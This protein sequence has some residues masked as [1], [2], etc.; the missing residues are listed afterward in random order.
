M[1]SVQNVDPPTWTPIWTSS[2]LL[3]PDPFWTPFWTPCFFFVSFLLLLFSAFF[4]R[5]YAYLVSEV[6]SNVKIEIYSSRKYWLS[7]KIKSE[8]NTIKSI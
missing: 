3:I 1:G 2:G 5:R 8:H 4:E 6:L 7:K